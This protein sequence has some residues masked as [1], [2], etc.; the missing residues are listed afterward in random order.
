MFTKLN[1]KDY[2]AIGVVAVLLF[3]LSREAINHKR[4]NRQNEAVKTELREQIARLVQ[5]KTETVV[6]TDTVIREIPRYYKE[7]VPQAVDSMLVYEIIDGRIA[8]DWAWDDFDTV[9]IWERTYRDSLVTGDFALPYRVSVLGE[10]N[11]ISFGNYRLF[12]EERVINHIVE[13][14]VVSVV[15]KSHLYFHCQFGTEAFER[16]ESVD[17]SLHYANRRGWGLLMGWQRFQSTNCF[18]AGVSLR[19][20]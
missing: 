7:Y 12:T 13:K 15:E 9:A 18:K 6:I 3:F 19:I 5:S 11:N 1:I 8:G 14:P 17:L 20:L 2:L 16:M 4:D 10:L